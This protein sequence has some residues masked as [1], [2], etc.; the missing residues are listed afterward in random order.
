MKTYAIIFDER[1]FGPCLLVLKSKMDLSC[2]DMIYVRMY[3][4][5]LGWKERKRRRRL[6]LKL[7]RFMY[8]EDGEIRFE[9]ASPK[10]FAKA[11]RK[12]AT[13]VCCGSY[14]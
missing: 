12:G 11:L 7:E 3:L 1:S 2:F 6:Q 5:D 9:P 14:R 4:K 10:R 8:N 13:L